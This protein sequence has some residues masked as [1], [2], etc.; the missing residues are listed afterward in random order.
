PPESY[1]LSSTDKTNYPALEKDIKVD[2]AI[3]GG[4]ITGITTAYLL[5]KEGLRVAVIEADRILQGTTAHTTAKITSQHG[6]IYN[7]L[8][9]YF[10][11]EKARQYAEANE[12]AISIISDLIKQENIDCDFH[13]EPA[14][15]FTLMDSYIQ[16]IAD[17]SNTA[18][19]LGIKASFIENIP[20]PFQVK[21]A[22]R[23]DNQARFHP[24]KYLL[25]LAKKVEGNDSFIFEN[26]RVVDI[27]K[28]NPCTVIT[29]QGKKVTADNV[30]I[31]S[32]FPCFDGMGFYFARMYPERS[33][34]L[35]VKVKE[36]FLGGM[37]ITAED[38]GRSLRSQ[39]YE[40]GELLI[41]AGEHHKTAHGTNFHKHY[42][43]LMEFAQK[44]YDLEELLFR[45]STQDYTTLDKIPY[46]GRLTSK[47]PNIFVA[48]GFRKWGMTNST[49]SAM[50]I[51]DLILKGE[52]PWAEV[53]DP[54]RFV[55][56]P[57]ITSFISINADVA[58]KLVTGKL[59]SVPQNINIERGEAKT[60]EMEGN[61]MGVYRDEKGQLH[62]VDTTCTHLGCE[63]KWNDAERSWDCPCHGSRFTY[64]GEI[65]EGPAINE[66]QHDCHDKNKIDPNIV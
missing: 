34:S 56:N 53:Y 21:G 55:P 57:S 59:K 26:T 61:K 40:G 1:W 28:G 64:E 14:Y 48:T 38:P 10:G 58:A 17:E 13:W 42:E 31:A 30:I 20:L 46:T 9:N 43:N 23:F 3:I 63:L 18:V 11:E 27:N 29:N 51:K 60:V 8:R 32:H 66:L 24:R 25:P 5:K 19:S 45:W 16:Q 22:V 41:V 47:T 44:H 4:G 54:S 2:A 49:V 37:Y 7:K 6:I 39:E 65:I 36:K 33:Y 15:I 62:A 12:A 52:N 50:I 35:A